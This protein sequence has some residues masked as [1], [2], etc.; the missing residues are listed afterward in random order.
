MTATWPL[1]ETKVVIP[2]YVGRRKT[3]AGAASVPWR[4]VW[5]HIEKHNPHS[6]ARDAFRGLPATG[7]GCTWVE[8][9]I[10]PG[11]PR[12]DTNPKSAYQL[13][14]ASKRDVKRYMKLYR[15]GTPFPRIVL[16]VRNNGQFVIH[17]GAHRLQAAVNLG[18]PIE[19]YVGIGPSANALPDTAD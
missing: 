2:A 11:D 7:E 6:D 4:T 16:E 13:Y 14:P 3:A 12:I 5:D 18:V 1:D 15:Q 17:D 19:A 8:E 9:T 10:Q